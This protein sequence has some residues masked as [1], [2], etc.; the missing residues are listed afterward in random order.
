[1]VRS[2]LPWCSSLA[3]ISGIAH[4]RGDLVS[5]DAAV[6][7]APDKQNGQAMHQIDRVARD[8]SVGAYAISA[9]AIGY[10]L[11]SACMI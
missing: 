8:E 7:C 6:A 3:K 5:Q 1:M 4:F 10:K 2:L 11:S 9:P